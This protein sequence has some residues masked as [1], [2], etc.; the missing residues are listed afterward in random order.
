MSVDVAQ[1]GLELQRPPLESVVDT[2]SRSCLRGQPCVSNPLHGEVP[3]GLI[4]PKGIIASKLSSYRIKDV[5]EE[6]DHLYLT[7]T[8]ELNKRTLPVAIL[9]GFI[10]NQT[11]YLGTLISAERPTFSCI[12][13]LNIPEIKCFKDLPDSSAF[14]IVPEF[15]NPTVPG[16]ARGFLSLAWQVLYEANLDN[17]EMRSDMTQRSTKEG[18]TSLYT[19]DNEGIINSSTI[20]IPLKVPPTDPKNLIKKVFDIF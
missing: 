19:L 15:R 2:L 18:Q 9:Y 11:S 13:G 5:S 4:T 16:L 20:T 6:L 3:I 8:R 1:E 14:Y 12:D 17:V 7:L 10:S